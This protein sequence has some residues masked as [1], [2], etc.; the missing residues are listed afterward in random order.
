ME[1]DSSTIS[2]CE[3]GA[4]F[5]LLNGRLVKEGVVVTISDPPRPQRLL[6]TGA[7]RPISI[8]FYFTDNALS[9]S[10]P[11]FSKQKAF[12]CL[13]A[14]IVYVYFDAAPEGCVDVAL[15][16]SSCES[17]LDCD[18]LYRLV[19]PTLHFENLNHFEQ[20]SSTWQCSS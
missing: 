16:L 1:T 19:M 8:T 3:Q 7:S 9:W 11:R 14:D 15:S 10:N 5:R 13:L 12:F 20:D 18:S 4:L 6:E 17:C 2:R